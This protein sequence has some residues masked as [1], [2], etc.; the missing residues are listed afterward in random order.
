MHAIQLENVTKTYPCAHAPAVRDISMEVPEGSIVTILGPSGCGKTTTL[1]LIAGFEKPDRG[2]ILLAGRT[3]SD[4]NSWVPPEKRDI[5]MVFQDY[6]L[7]P[8]LDVFHNVGFGYRGKDRKARVLEVLELVNLAGYGKRAPHELSGGQQQRV[9]LARALAR[10][11]VVV[12][13]DEPFSNLDAEL[14]GYMRLEVKRIIKETGT[15][16]VFVSHDQKDALAISDNIIVMKEG[17]IQQRGTPREIYRF[18]ENKFV[19]TFVGQSNILKGVI[20]RDSRSLETSLGVIPCSHTHNHKPGEEVYIS[21]RPDS[22]E[23]AGDGPLTGRV[24]RLTYTG[25]A[26][27]AEVEVEDLEGKRRDLLTHIHPERSVSIGDS[28]RFK[29]L[30]EFV[31]VMSR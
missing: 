28:V 5:G 18:P 31:A 15:T 12:M 3:V 17:L 30:P 24:R 10:R 26:Y 21:I 4:E 20:A 27:E 16:A 6:A 29:I 2:R 19:A 9:A 8:H 22:L 11:P 14:K 1:H 25:E 7:F 13:L 23:M